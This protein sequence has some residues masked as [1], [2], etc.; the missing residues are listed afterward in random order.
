MLHCAYVLHGSFVVS[1][2][3]RVCVKLLLS[4]PSVPEKSFILI[5]NVF[6]AGLKS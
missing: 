5:Y 4:G 1:V 2:I 6:K 3:S